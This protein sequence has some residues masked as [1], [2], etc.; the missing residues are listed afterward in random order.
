ML[1]NSA[2]WDIYHL[3]PVDICTFSSRDT[4]DFWARDCTENLILNLFLNLH[5]WCVVPEVYLVY[6]R[7]RMSTPAPQLWPSHSALSSHRMQPSK[8]LM[9]CFRPQIYPGHHVALCVAASSSQYLDTLDTFIF[10]IPFLNNLETNSILWY[11]IQCEIIKN[12]I[13]YH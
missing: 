5:L 1:F 2:N 3:Y 13:E 7:S 12:V 10:H 9:E 8:Q 6:L 11:N 4:E